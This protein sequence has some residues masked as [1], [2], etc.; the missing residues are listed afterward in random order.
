MRANGE[1]FHL[2]YFETIAEAKAAY[3]TAAVATFGDFASD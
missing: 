1:Y 3:Q 2:G